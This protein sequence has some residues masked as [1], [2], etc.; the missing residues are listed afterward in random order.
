MFRGCSLCVQTVQRGILLHEAGQ[1]KARDIVLSLS[2]ERG[3]C[4][5]V[6]G[7]CFSNIKVRVFHFIIKKEDL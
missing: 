2:L 4:N 5:S 7:D 1:A 6:S 3:S